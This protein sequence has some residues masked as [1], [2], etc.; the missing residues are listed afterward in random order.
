MC[1]TPMNHGHSPALPPEKQVPPRNKYRNRWTSALPKWVPKRPVKFC[2]PKNS[3][4]WRMKRY[5][6]TAISIWRIKQN[7]PNPGPTRLRNFFSRNSGPDV[8]PWNC[9][10]YML[11]V[12]KWEK[13]FPHVFWKKTSTQNTWTW[14]CE[15]V[16]ESQHASFLSSPQE[17]WYLFGNRVS[18]FILK[19]ILLH[20]PAFTTETFYT[21]QVAHLSY[22]FTP[23]S[24]YTRH[25]LHQPAFTRDTFYTNQLLH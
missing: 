6:Y 12:L 3:M 5:V 17:K 20:Q 2:L 1:F 16:N 7:K 9:K 11:Y 21:T 13:L 15:G 4:A 23:T 24:F 22:T 14:T 10:K 18:S 25:L 8:W 19:R